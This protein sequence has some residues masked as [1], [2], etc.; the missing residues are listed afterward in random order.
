MKVRR[1]VLALGVLVSYLLADEDLLN[2]IGIVKIKDSVL[3]S[4]A[5]GF[6]KV[7]NDSLFSFLGNLERAFEKSRPFYAQYYLWLD[8][9]STLNTKLVNAEVKKSQLPNFTVG[10]H[11]KNDSLIQ[12]KRLKGTQK[13]EPWESVFFKRLEKLQSDPP[14]LRKW[15]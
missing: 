14:I 8:S 2:P 9:C 10:C 5:G 4:A 6:Q 7:P 11:N 1:I 13:T 15:K 12:C 3:I